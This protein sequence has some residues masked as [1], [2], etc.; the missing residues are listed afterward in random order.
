MF[1][2]T[3]TEGKSKPRMV[4]TS[5]IITQLVNCCLMLF[6]VCVCAPLFFFFS[7]ALVFLFI[8]LLFFIIIVFCFALLCARCSIFLFIYFFWQLLVSLRLRLLLLF[9]SKLMSWHLSGIVCCWSSWKCVSV[10]VYVCVCVRACVFGAV[11]FNSHESM[12]NGNWCVHFRRH[13]HRRLCRC[14]R[15]RRRCM[16]R[17]VLILLLLNDNIQTFCCCFCFPSFFYFILVC[18]LLFWFC[19]LCERSKHTNA[20]TSTQTVVVIIHHF[21]KAAHKYIWLR[22]DGGI[23]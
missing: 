18:C 8:T 1:E 23:Y 9:L 3:H 20:H 14:H 5:I 22:I 17:M 16:S 21:N 4:C 15:C 2:C 6:G 10:F 19:F 7:F 11:L 12:I 13:H